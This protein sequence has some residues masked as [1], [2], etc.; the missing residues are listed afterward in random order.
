MSS[1]YTYFGLELRLKTN[2]SLFAS[3][4]DQKYSIGN[5]LSTKKLVSHPV[6]ISFTTTAAQNFS[7]L[8]S[9]D[10]QYLGDNAWQ[11]ENSFRLLHQYLTTNTNIVATLVDGSDQLDSLTFEFADSLAFN[12]VSTLTGGVLKQQLLQLVIKQYIEQAL[13]GYLTTRANLQC[14][15]AAVIEKNG[16]A[17][18]LAG[19]NGVGK[20]SLALH[21]IQTQGY[22]LLADN[23]VLLQG[24]QAL[25]TPDTV[26]LKTDSIE[27]LK[28]TASGLFGFEKYRIAD[29]YWSPLESAPIKSIW[30][31]S[32][33]SSWQLKPANS[34]SSNKSNNPSSAEKIHQQIYKRQQLFGE[35]VLLS[36]VMNLFSNAQTGVI[37][38]PLKVDYG[39]LTLGNWSTIPKQLSLE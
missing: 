26:R 25:R 31:V 9:K 34:S 6:T 20:S 33:G 2:H 39:L 24:T 4:F 13:L 37:P 18:V 35:D 27:Q 10:I 19:L 11:T 36:P 14:L 8:A 23:Y 32:R 22:R 29:Q 28:L 38:V 3:L 1:T 7:H 15:H 21:L 16:Q 5:T 30:L 17:V 12:L